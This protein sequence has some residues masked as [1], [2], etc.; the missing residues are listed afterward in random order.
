MSGRQACKKKGR[1]KDRKEETKLGTSNYLAKGCDCC[2]TIKG[3]RNEGKRKH[4]T[5]AIVIHTHI[6]IYMHMYKFYIHIYTYI[7]IY[8]YIYI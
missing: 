1:K 3:R 2:I 6:Y 8:I 5:R 7:Y 4:L